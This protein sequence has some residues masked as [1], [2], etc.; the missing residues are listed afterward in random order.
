MG[1]NGFSQNMLTTN[2]LF[3]LFLFIICVSFISLYLVSTIIENQRK[4]HKDKAENLAEG[5][6]SNSKFVNNVRVQA[7]VTI[8]QHKIQHLKATK[9]KILPTTL[10]QPQKKGPSVKGKTVVPVR[11]GPLR[12]C[13]RS[14]AAPCLL[15][16]VGARWEAKPVLDFCLLLSAVIPHCSRSHI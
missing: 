6:G 5:V 13:C 10:R 14:D 9:T 7:H 4:L 15:F 1:L 3:T 2:K 11:E 12:L 16:E 8:R